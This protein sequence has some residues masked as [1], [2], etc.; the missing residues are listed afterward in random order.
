[1]GKI[2][3]TILGAVIGGFAAALAMVALFGW[4]VPTTGQVIHVDPT[5][6]DYI[7]LL[8]LI[9][10][11]FL[12]AIGLTVTVG[13]LVIGLVALKSLREIKEDAAAEAKTAAATKI[14]EHISTEL[15][16]SVNAKVDEALPSALQTALLT[17]E[18][19]HKILTEMAQRGDLDDVLERV[20][21]R[22]QTGGP[23]ESENG[24]EEG[25][26]DSES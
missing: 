26:S 12:A 16:P 20:A 5:R 2:S 10:T 13:A 25:F 9:A 23:E 17:N 11:I 19:G 8:L 4:G 21:T 22:M 1:M 15:A 7:D 24:T 14:T 18:I 3:A 6:S